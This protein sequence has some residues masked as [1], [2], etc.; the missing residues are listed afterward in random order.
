MAKRARKVIDDYPG[1][2]PNLDPGKLPDG[3]SP[4]Q[5]NLVCN[6]VGRLAT[7]RGLRPMQSDEIV[8]V[9]SLLADEEI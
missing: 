9:S 2:M 4:I 7:R 5:I 8:V 3:A 6:K 1:W